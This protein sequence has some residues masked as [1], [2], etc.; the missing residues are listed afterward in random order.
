MATL[1]N[2]ESEIDPTKYKITGSVIAPLGEFMM[3]V[4][5]DLRRTGVDGGSEGDV[6]LTDDTI[7]SRLGGEII[8]AIVFEY[9]VADS[10]TPQSPCQSY[11]E[12]NYET[13]VITL[14]S[15]RTVPSKNRVGL[16][17]FSPAKPGSG[18]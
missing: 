1:M 13:K 6:A 12:I 10:T 8:G 14:K 11:V 2:V 17:V 15:I 16:L 9:S 18:V 5:V 4:F 7:K 3:E